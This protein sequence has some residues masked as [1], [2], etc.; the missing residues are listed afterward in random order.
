[1]KQWT[2]D[3]TSVGLRAD[4]YIS[5]HSDY[6]R[7]KVNEMIKNESILVNHHSIKA[8][9]KLHLN[10]LIELQDY[11]EKAHDLA[12]VE[13]KLD[14]VYEDDYLIIVNKPSG[15][16][17]HPSKGN[18]NQSLL[19][20]LIHYYQNTSFK[21][22]IVHRL[23]KQ[24]S[25]LLIVAKDMMT[26]RLLASAIENKEVQRYYRAL[27]KGDFTENTCWVRHKISE[28]LKLKQMVLDPENGKEA[29]TE[30][31]KIASNQSYSLLEYHLFTGRKHQI[32]IHSQSLGFP[33]LNDPIY[34]L[35][36]FDPDY[37]QFLCAFKLMF[38]HPRT[39]E[40][41]EFTIPLPEEFSQ[42][43]QF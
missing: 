14:I 37:G 6:S 41:L 27:V 8:N 7:S 2:I 42:Y 12:P 9:Y 34:A 22:G 28:S 25:G 19:Q 39:H 35:E 43:I 16:V 5:Q 10:D 11:V 36:S 29:V 24:T 40:N 17:V 18:R 30:V 3:T 23:D 26:H 4:I 32:R 13:M 15:L 33:I 1:M 20:G 31:L 21:P 38:T